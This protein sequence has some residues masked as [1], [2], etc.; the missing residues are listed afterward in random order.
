ML[1]V[2]SI[3]YH[4]LIKLLLHRYN[5]GD[6]KVLKIQRN[7]KGSCKPAQD[8]LDNPV[9]QFI[10]SQERGDKDHQSPGARPPELLCSR[11]I[12]KPLRDCTMAKL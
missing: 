9:F 7:L 8:N 6:G 5:W 2:S 11:L 10:N 4:E 12:E 3:N 1:L